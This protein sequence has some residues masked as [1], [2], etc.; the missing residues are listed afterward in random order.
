[1][2]NRSELSEVSLIND[3]LRFRYL[4]P[5]RSGYRNFQFTIMSGQH[6]QETARQLESL[7]ASIEELDV[8]CD[9]AAPPVS[10]SS[11]RLKNLT[12]SRTEISALFIPIG[13]LPNDYKGLVQAAVPWDSEWSPEKF[14]AALRQLAEVVD[15]ATMMQPEPETDTEINTWFVNHWHMMFENARLHEHLGARVNPSTPVTTVMR[16]LYE[17]FAT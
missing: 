2:N 7:A 15:N 9:A 17:K 6:P 12:V 10:R 14:S 11:Y 3:V 4:M 16:G 5:G 8:I 13:N 1:M